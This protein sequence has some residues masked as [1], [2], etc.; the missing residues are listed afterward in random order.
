MTE[1][2]N[3]NSNE[4]QERALVALDGS[5]SKKKKRKKKYSPGFRMIQESI[6]ASSKMSEQMAKAQLEGIKEFN[7]RWDQAARKKRDGGLVDVFRISAKAF[8]KSTKHMA[9][10]PEQYMENSGSLGKLL[11]PGRMTRSTLKAFGF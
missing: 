1:E 4:A 11:K 7:K 3:E 2:N 9:D 5:D 8:A 10:A 6:Y